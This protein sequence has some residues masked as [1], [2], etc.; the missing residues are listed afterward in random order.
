MELGEAVS[1]ADAGADE[2][3]RSHRICLRLTLDADAELSLR[4]HA[5]GYDQS[6][7]AAGNQADDQGVVEVV[8]EDV[9]PQGSYTLTASPGDGTPDY[10]VFAEV[11][12]S[13]FGRVANAG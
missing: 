13:S 8:F 4:L 10:D 2:D 7:R 12:Y 6:R 9:D 11:P 5:S 1:S 3:S